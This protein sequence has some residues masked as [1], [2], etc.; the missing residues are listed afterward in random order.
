MGGRNAEY[1]LKLTEEHVRALEELDYRQQISTQ[2]PEAVYRLTLLT[3]LD[4]QKAE[5]AQAFSL[6]NELDR[7]YGKT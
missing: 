4:K 5:E 6:Y 1:I 2:N 7:K 3:T